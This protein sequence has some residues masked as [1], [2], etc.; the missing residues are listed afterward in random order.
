MIRWVQANPHACALSTISLL[1]RT[2]GLEE[3]RG[4]P[5]VDHIRYVQ[6]REVHLL[7]LA[8]RST[9]QAGPK[10]NS[11]IARAS[12]APIREGIRVGNWE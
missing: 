9:T 7:E 12:Y 8:K 1:W 11:A 2:I 10:V 4:S 5:A 6:R 3:M